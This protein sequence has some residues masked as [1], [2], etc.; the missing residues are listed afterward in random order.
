MDIMYLRVIITYVG[1]DTF[2]KR[3]GIFSFGTGQVGSRPY[4]KPGSPNP[5]AYQRTLNHQAFGVVT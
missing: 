3:Y 5:F 2:K 1:Y 4:F